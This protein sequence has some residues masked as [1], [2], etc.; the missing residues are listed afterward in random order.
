MLTTNINYLCGS[1][2]VRLFQIG[3]LIKHAFIL[4]Q[5]K[6]DNTFKQYRSACSK[7]GS[8]LVHQDYSN[9]IS[10]INYQCNLDFP[11]IYKYTPEYMILSCYLCN[12]TIRSTFFYYLFFDLI[13]NSGAVSC[14]LISYETDTLIKYLYMSL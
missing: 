9:P 14:S 12:I 11:M 10:I 4:H 7:K 5:K 1:L 2:M 6:Y 8:L 13:I 3:Y